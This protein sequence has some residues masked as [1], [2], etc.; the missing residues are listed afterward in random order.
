MSAIF[1]RD[2]AKRFVLMHRDSGA[3]ER[4]ALTAYVRWRG[5]TSREK[6]QP[7]MT[8]RPNVRTDVDAAVEAV[9]KEAQRREADSTMRRKSTLGNPNDVS[10]T[11]ALDAHERVIG[12]DAGK[13]FG[14]ARRLFEEWAGARLAKWT[15]GNFEVRDWHDFARWLSDEPMRGNRRGDRRSVGGVKQYTTLIATALNGAQKLKEVVE[16]G[17][18]SH[19]IQLCEDTGKR[20]VWG[21]GKRSVEYVLN[22]SAAAEEEGFDEGCLDPEQFAQ[23]FDRVNIH[24]LRGAGLWRLVL[25][26]LVTAGRVRHVLQADFRPAEDG[27]QL[28]LDWKEAGCHWIDLARG[29]PPRWMSAN[30][31]RA[32]VRLPERFGE[33]LRTDWAMQEICQIG[34]P[35]RQ[36]RNPERFLQSKF[37]AANPKTGIHLTP[38]VLRHSTNT[39]LCDSWGVSIA[40]VERMLGHSAAVN[41]KHYR[42]RTPR[43]QAMLVKSVEEMIEEISRKSER[44][45]ALW[46]D[47]KT[48]A[49]KALREALAAVN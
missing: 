20:W 44:V 36:D 27:G 13:G 24:S 7:E 1:Y 47:D 23:W 4:G 19:E 30:K 29:I 45:R 46:S 16:S 11:D 42:H 25:T 6:I 18:E 5:E 38:K 14:P 43:S 3:A 39:W 22:R 40:E 12:F 33:I 15:I 35:W 37:T 34:R 49:A 32:D 26:G 8:V 2:P 17:G 31:R 41:D 48:P 28:F 9:M 21:A 10:L